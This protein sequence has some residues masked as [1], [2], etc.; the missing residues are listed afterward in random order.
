MLYKLQLLS[1]TILLVNRNI[2]RHTNECP[3][4]NI[5]EVLLRRI[6]NCC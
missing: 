3:M 6:S 4:A 1:N 2:G 5:I